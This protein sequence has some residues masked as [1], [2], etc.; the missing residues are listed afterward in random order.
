MSNL[1]GE[2]TQALEVHAPLTRAQLFDQCPSAEEAQ[3]ISRVLWRMKESGEV[4]HDRVSGAYTL[5]G[6]TPPVT[7]NRTPPVAP[8]NSNEPP[9]DHTDTAPN[10]CAPE[11]PSALD[12]ALA[13]EL[14]FNSRLRTSIER[15][16][17]AIDAYVLT[18]NDP[19]LV[20]LLAARDSLREL[21]G[22]A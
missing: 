21:E 10:A 2:I 19:H 16:D 14:A 17:R 7:E 9:A 11:P 1:R 22:A 13:A 12:Q 4:R 8:A 15:L 18:L 20:E 6:Q 3:Q 5:A